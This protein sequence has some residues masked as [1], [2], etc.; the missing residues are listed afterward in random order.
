MEAA[1]AFANLSLAELGE[2]ETVQQLDGISLRQPEPEI[3]YL[4]VGRLVTAKPIRFHFFKDT[5]AS[6]W[7]PVMGMNVMELKPRLYLFRFFHKKELDRIIDDGPWMYEQSLLLLKKL[8]PHE[9]PEAVTLSHADFWIQIHGL[10]VGCRSEAVLQAIGQFVGGLIKMD[11]KNFDGSLRAFYRIRVALN[12]S[13]PLKKGM[14]LKKDDG[15]WFTILFQYERLP[16]FCFLCGMIGHGEKQCAKWLEEGEQQKEKPFSPS[17]RAGTRRN[18]PT[19]GEQWIAPDTYADRKLW[20]ASG[21]E[22]AMDNSAEKVV[23][24]DSRRDTILNPSNYVSHN[25]I[26]NT[27]FKESGKQNI[28][29]HI[30]G[31]V[32]MGTPDTTSALEASTAGGKGGNNNGGNPPPGSNQPTQ[33]FSCNNIENK[34]A[35]KNKGKEK[36]QTT[37]TTTIVTQMVENANDGILDVVD[38][39]RQ[40][41]GEYGSGSGMDTM[42]MDVETLGS[43]NGDAAGLA[44]QARPEL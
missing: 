16:T 18:I 23:V 38:Q 27:F 33:P 26:N 30:S 28:G 5:M 22:T 19:S 36:V 40:R 2:E 25:T 43:K 7:Q 4:A 6:I 35:Q 11:E 12:V 8:E 44:M 37:L 21:K 1:N 34:E 13:K 32:E 29:T 3:V 24:G 41:V 17:L 15:E 20:R 9:D 39:K 10:P 14:R 42:A 31:D